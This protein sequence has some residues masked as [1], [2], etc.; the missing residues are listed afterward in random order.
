M[1]DEN[2]A[3]VNSIGMRPIALLLTILTLG[4]QG[5]LRPPEDVGCDRNE[6]TAHAGVV[7][8]YSRTAGKV[9]VTI[10]TD[11]QTREKASF[12]DSRLRW[13]GGEFQPAHWKQIEKGKTRAVAWVCAKGGGLLD[14][15]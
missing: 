1:V 10:R 7:A 11:E 8:D 3:M 13:R 2:L 14:F 15:Q 5:R 9:T 4:A 12:D 6:L